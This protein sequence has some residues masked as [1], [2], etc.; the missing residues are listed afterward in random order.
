MT[1]TPY[2]FSRWFQMK[3]LVYMI[4]FA[5]AA[6]SAAD[7]GAGPSGGDYKVPGGPNPGL[8]SVISSFQFSG[9]TAPYALGIC[10]D[11][12]YVYGVMYGSP[13]FLRTYTKTGSIVGSVTLTGFTTSRGGSNCHLGT[14][15]FT[16][17]ENSGYILRHVNKTTGATAG[18]FGVS[19]FGSQLIDNA[20]D[21]TYYYV[22]GGTA[23]GSFQRYTTA[24]S[25]AGT[26]T[27]SGFPAN[28]GGDGYATKALN[29][30]G[31]YMVV[32]SW[33]AS[34]TCSV[35]NIATGAVVG[36]FVPSGANFNGLEVG[37]SS[38]PATVGDTIW[39]NEYISAQLWCYQRQLDN[40][41]GAVAPA[42]IGHVKALYR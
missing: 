27:F 42:S 11:D 18:S 30:A 29:V 25:S 19:G 7:L 6:A 41:P 34:S 5:A 22:A 31:S 10:V 16:I 17:A 8:G 1:I 32:G 9:L 37:A 39:G 4:T 35:V 36:S 28:V 3:R 14:G 26:W 15:Y 20:F 2:L 40:L 38:T 13:C 24:G 33:A 23:N 12:N 21:G